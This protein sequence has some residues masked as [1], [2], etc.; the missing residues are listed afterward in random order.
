MIWS[1]PQGPKG[2][3]RVCA[4]SRCSDR[5]ALNGAGKNR[6]RKSYDVFDYDSPLLIRTSPPFP[7]GPP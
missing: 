4:V 5:A 2:S 7:I 3:C 6:A 1:L